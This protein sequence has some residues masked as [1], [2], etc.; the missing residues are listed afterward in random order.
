ML[1]TISS[2]CYSNYQELAKVCMKCL[3][4]LALDFSGQQALQKLTNKWF[5]GEDGG[6]YTMHYAFKKHPD[7]AEDFV[8]CIGSFARD[9]QRL[10]FVYL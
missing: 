10:E 5:A 9:S 8:N 2:G 3:S 6:F 4:C 1:H 7:L